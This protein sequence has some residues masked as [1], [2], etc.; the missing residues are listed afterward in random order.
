[1]TVEETVTQHVAPPI[2]VHETPVHDQAWA[3]LRQ[4]I[5]PV[6]AF[7]LGKGILDDSEATLIIS[8]S[9]IILPIVWGQLKTRLRAKQLAVLETKVPDN[10]LTT[11]AKAANP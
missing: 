7:L 8:G 2:V 3:L 9:A 6:V 4:L 10:V 5:P 1:M 11:K